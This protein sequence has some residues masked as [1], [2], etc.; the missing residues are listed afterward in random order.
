MSRY[1]RR[2]DTDRQAIFRAGYAS[3]G[4]GTL[5]HPPSHEPTRNAV[6]RDYHAA[7]EVELEQAG[8]AGVLRR[9]GRRGLGGVAR[10]SDGSFCVPSVVEAVRLAGAVAHVSGFDAADLGAAAGQHDAPGH[11]AWSGGVRLFSG[12]A[13]SSFHGGFGSCRPPFSLTVRPFSYTKQGGTSRRTR[14]LTEGQPVLP[15]GLP[16]CRCRARPAAI[17]QVA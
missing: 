7:L 6:R 9:G 2:R 10:R 14:A 16:G 5:A 17:H 1:F 3:A 8:M 12:A 4:R 11:A 13:G 15:S